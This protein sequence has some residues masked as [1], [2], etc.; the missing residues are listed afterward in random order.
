MTS[1]GLPVSIELDGPAGED[2]ALL[3]LGLTIEG[4]LGPI[5]APEIPAAS[6][7]RPD[8]RAGSRRSA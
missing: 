4:V 6:A 3:A 7:A 5:P 8:P 2:R 1:G